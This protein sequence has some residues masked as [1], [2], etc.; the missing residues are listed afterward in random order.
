MTMS[1]S[2]R[3]YYYGVLGAMGGL[4]GWQAS[5]MVGLSF[6][7]SLYLSEIV[8]GGLIG[9]SIGALIGYRKDWSRAS[10]CWPSN[11]VCSAVY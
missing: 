5:N 6:W 4:I 11:L 9:F 3:L 1:R 7:S 10:H 8:V 2:M